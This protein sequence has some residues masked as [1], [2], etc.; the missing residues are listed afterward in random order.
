MA[1]LTLSSSVTTLS[2][3]LISTKS[4]VNQSTELEDVLPPLADL[5]LPTPFP[6]PEEAMISVLKIDSTLSDLVSHLTK[7]PIYLVQVQGRE[8]VMDLDH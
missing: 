5:E 4:L 1:R 2:L 6:S 8:K 7:E 3:I